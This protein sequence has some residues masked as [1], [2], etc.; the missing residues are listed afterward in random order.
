MADEKPQKKTKVYRLV[1]RQHTGLDK[2]GNAKDYRQ[3][4]KVSLTEREYEAFRDKFEPVNA[5]DAED[6]E[7]VLTPAAPAVKVNPEG[8]DK[9][10]TEEDKK[11][12]QQDKPT[13]ST[14]AGSAAQ[15]TNTKKV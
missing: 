11:K 5:Q 15:S 4:D 13:P 6:D 7:P 1:G 2:E 14:G 10:Q 9:V 8:A 12:T 3:G